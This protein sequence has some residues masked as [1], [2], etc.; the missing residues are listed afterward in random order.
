ME[1]AKTKPEADTSFNPP[2]S[3]K[4]M[5]PEAAAVVSQVADALAMPTEQPVTAHLANPSS[6][7]RE[8]SN[9]RVLG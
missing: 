9:V 2:K 3:D 6:T 5:Q 8:P 4:E 1:R 7:R